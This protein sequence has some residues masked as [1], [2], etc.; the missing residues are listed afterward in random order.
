MVTKAKMTMR[1]D[2]DGERAANSSVDI[3]MIERDNDKT[4]RDNETMAGSHKEP[5]NANA[6]ELKRFRTTAE[7]H[8]SDETMK[9]DLTTRKLMSRW[10]RATECWKGPRQSGIGPATTEIELLM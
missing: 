9:V 3:E 7:A 8:A 4:A 5:V 1:T 10:R 6:M 2:N